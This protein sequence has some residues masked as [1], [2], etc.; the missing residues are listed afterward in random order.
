MIF[1]VLRRLVVYY[2]TAWTMEVCMLY[3]VGSFSK[4]YRPVGS[5]TDEAVLNGTAV[6]THWAIRQVV[7]GKAKTYRVCILPDNR[8]YVIVRVGNGRNAAMALRFLRPEL[9]CDMVADASRGK[10]DVRYHDTHV[11]P[12]RMGRSERGLVTVDQDWTGLLAL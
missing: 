3:L 5:Y 7:D 10:T 11:D 9:C 4:L 1:K 2:L 8:M 12:D 6:R